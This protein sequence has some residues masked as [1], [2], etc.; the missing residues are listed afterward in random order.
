MRFTKFVAAIILGLS[1]V[2]GAAQAQ[3]W[4]GYYGGLSFGKGNG[5]VDYGAD[6]GALDA[7]EGSVFGGF[8][9]YNM[10]NGN[11][12]YGGE[13]AYS[14]SNVSDVS[15]PEE[16]YEDFIDLKGRVGFASGSA[17]Y[18]GVLGYSFDSYFREG[19]ATIDSTGSGV[20]FGLGAEFAVG[21]Q[22]FMG[23]EVLR[24]DLSN[25]ANPEYVALDGVID[26]VSV[27]FGMSF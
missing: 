1:G 6:G 2:T 26:T 9:G 4:S 20:A 3:D 24:R 27:R 18:Y 23:A 25:D 16:A 5:D 10:Q 7:F 14:K 12:V 15:F 11:L 13:F 8:V 17:L 19:S 22:F 21:E